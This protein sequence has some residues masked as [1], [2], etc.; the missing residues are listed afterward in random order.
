MHK[1]HAKL[2]GKVS[3]ELLSFLE[4]ITLSYFSKH[5]QM[6]STLCPKLFWVLELLLV[7]PACSAIDQVS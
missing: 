6:Y 1:S 7:R 2:R 4:L 5:G 3:S